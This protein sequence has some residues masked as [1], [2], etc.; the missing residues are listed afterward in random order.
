[1]F[2]ISYICGIL[3]GSSA[4]FTEKKTQSFFYLSRY[5]CSYVILQTLKLFSVHYDPMILLQFPSEHFPR[6][7]IFVGLYYKSNNNRATGTFI[8]SVS[9]PIR[10]YVEGLAFSGNLS[11]WVIKSHICLYYFILRRVSLRLH[12]V[13]HAEIYKELSLPIYSRSVNVLQTFLVLSLEYL[14]DPSNS[15][16]ILEYP[17]RNIPA[18]S[19]QSI[20][21]SSWQQATV[22]YLNC[23]RTSLICAFFFPFN[24]VYA[25]YLRPSWLYI[26]K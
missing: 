19:T 11:M 13:N 15:V 3:W 22:L 14:M 4:S 20:A 8:F 12:W 23:C 16:F 9:L 25:E 21:A 18:V 1:M 2:S 26:F 17:H 24:S 6:Y 5:P 7:S 10:M